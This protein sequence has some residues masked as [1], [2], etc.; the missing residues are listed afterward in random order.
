M[1]KNLTPI[2]FSEQLAYIHIVY[3]EFFNV[4]S[5]LL[6]GKLR[7]QQFWALY[8]THCIVQKHTSNSPIKGAR[9]RDQNN[10]ATSMTVK[11]K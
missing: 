9:Q 4:A 8:L 6:L 10:T 1:S 5:D 11:V 2:G 7:S 3:V